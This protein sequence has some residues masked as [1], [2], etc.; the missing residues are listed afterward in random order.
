MPF[1]TPILP[2][3]REVKNAST[4]KHGRWLLVGFEGSDQRKKAAVWWVG[5][6]GEILGG[7][8]LLEIAQHPATNQK[9]KTRFEE[10]MLLLWLFGAN[11]WK[12]AP[13][14]V[15][16]VL[17]SQLVRCSECTKSIQYKFVLIYKVVA[18]WIFERTFS[19]LVCRKWPLHIKQATR[20]F[21]EPW[22]LYLYKTRY[23]SSITRQTTGRIGTLLQPTS[24]T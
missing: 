15:I 10:R 9:P 1:P 13:V 18:D 17:Y 7:D 16:H 4:L 23:F 6:G 14:P 8:T 19:I 3:K 5:F 2:H 20:R 21:T 12:N 11:F 22:T 24:K